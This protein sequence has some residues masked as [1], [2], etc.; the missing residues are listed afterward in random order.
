MNLVKGNNSPLYRRILLAGLPAL[1]LA[2]CNLP[3]FVRARF[4]SPTPT[5]NEPHSG[6]ESTAVPSTAAPTPDP[7]AASQAC[8]AGDWQ[9]SDLSRYVMAAIP[10]EQ[11]KEYGLEYRDTSG[12]AYFSLAPGGRFALT[13]DQFEMVFGAKIS[14][15]SVPV[16]V[17]FDGQAL[18]SYSLQGDTLTITGVDTSG[19]QAYAQAMG[20]NLMEPA[21][22]VRA[23]PFMRP[24]H[25]VARFTCG[26]DQLQL[27]LLSA[28]DSLPPLT[29]TRRP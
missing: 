20:N 9:I 6:I 27:K 21:Q 17:G 18:G 26:G 1:V 28:S 2:A 14:I 7:L 22:I 15:L 8:L 11:A 24:P 13:A 4:A 23:I 5:S 10:P 16:A 25:N 29:F 3:A 12:A 19:L